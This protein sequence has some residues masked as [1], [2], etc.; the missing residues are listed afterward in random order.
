MTEN[1]LLDLY[2]TLA[3][4]PNDAEGNPLTPFGNFCAGYEA[5]AELAE[6]EIAELQAQINVLRGALLEIAE[7][8]ASKHG[9]TRMM[10]ERALAISNESLAKT[11]PQCLQEHDNEVIERCAKEVETLLEVD[12]YTG[13]LKLLLTD[14]NTKLTLAAQYV[15]K[16]KAKQN[17]I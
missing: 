4:L 2:K 8:N 7:T 13:K 3:Y 12:P 1:E 9:T 6:K 5:H 11:A 16:L 14:S 10:L 17:A 15:R